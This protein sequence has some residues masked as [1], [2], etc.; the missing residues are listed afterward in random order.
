MIKNYNILYSLPFT[1]NNGLI[2]A[3]NS[4][5][6]AHAR[7]F[8]STNEKSLQYRKPLETHIDKFSNIEYGRNF[9]LW[10]C[11]KCKN[12]WSSAYTWISLNFCFNNKEILKIKDKQDKQKMEEWFSCDKL[13]DKYFLVEECRDCCDKHNN[14]VKILRYRNLKWS[15]ERDNHIPHRED[16]CVKCIKGYKCTERFYSTL[17]RTL[18]PVINNYVISKRFF[19]TSTQE[20]S[21][22]N[23]KSF[24]DVFNSLPNNYVKLKNISNIRGWVKLYCKDINLIDLRPNVLFM[25]KFYEFNTPYEYLYHELYYFKNN[26]L[27]LQKNYSLYLLY[28]PD[29]LILYS[30]IDLIKDYYEYT[31]N[32]TIIPKNNK[33]KYKYE[34][35]SLYLKIGK[36]LV[37]NCLK[38][39]YSNYLEINNIKIFKCGF[40]TFLK[41]NQDFFTFVQYKKYIIE[42]EL[43]EMNTSDFIEY[44][45]DIYLFI[46]YNIYYINQGFLE[47]DNTYNISNNSLRLNKQNE[48]SLLKV[49]KPK[50]GTYSNFFPSENGILKARKSYLGWKRNFFGKKNKR[51]YN[52]KSYDAILD[53]NYKFIDN[54]ILSKEDLDLNIKEYNN[55]NNLNINKENLN[56]CYINSPQN[57]YSIF[58]S[59]VFKNDVFKLIYNNI[60]NIIENNPINN[61]TQYKIENYLINQYK[62]LIFNK[63]KLYISDIDF[64]LFNKEFKNYCFSKIDEF[65]SYLNLLRD[66]LNS[67][68][69]YNKNINDFTQSIDIHNFYIKN[70]FNKLNNKEIISYMF[71]VLFLVV[72]YNDMVSTEDN[73]KDDEKTKIGVT[74]I[75]MDLGKI[76]SNFYITKLYKEYKKDNNI[77]TLEFRIFKERFLNVDKQYVFEDS[78][79]FLRLSGKLIEIMTTCGV[80]DIKIH[81]LN[82]RNLVVLKLSSDL[83]KVLD[84]KNPISILP[85]NLPMIVPPKDYNDNDL[86]GFLLN[87]VEYTQYLIRPKLGY[88]TSS[89]IEENN[90]IYD[91]VNSMMKTPFKVNKD[92][93]NYLL[94]NNHIHNLL[95][96]SDYKHEYSDIKRNKIQEKKYQ[97]FLSQ[98]MLEKYILLIADIYS[99]IPEIYFPLKLDN[100]GRL[101]PS[102]AFFHYQSSELA[103]ALIQFAIPDI[104]K[105][106]DHNAIEYLKTYGATCFGNGLNRKSYTK[107]LEWIKENW[108]NI[109]NFENGYL[110]S[111]A[112]DKFLFLAFCFEIRRFNTFMDNEHIDEFKTYLPI[113]LDGTCNGFQHLALLSNET[114][115]F[116]NLNLGESKKN[117]DPSDFYTHILD[118]LNIH[119]VRSARK[120]RG[121]DS[122]EIKERIERLLKLGLNRSLLKPIIM[123]DPYNATNRTLASYV[124][125]LLIY[126]HSDEKKPLLDKEGKQIYDKNNNPK[127]ESI[128]WYKIDNSSKYF[129]NFEDLEFLVKTID[130]IIYVKYP[131]IKILK[132]YFRDIGKIF[133]D[134]NI[135]IIWRLPTGLKVSQQYMEKHTIQINPFSYHSNRISLTITDKLKIDKHKQLSA[136]MPNLV[137]SLDAA[138]LT[139]L[140]ASLTKTINLNN[141][142]INFYSVHDCYGVTAKYVD[143]LIKMLR[144]VYIE[145]YSGEGYIEKFDEDVINTIIITYGENLCKYS[146]ENRTIYIDKRKNIVLPNLSVFLNVP[147]KTRVYKNL[148]KSIFLIK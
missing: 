56:T 48:L 130:E 107:R 82:D 145:L 42:K 97:K 4:M 101:Y 72:T 105:R 40:K 118:I 46:T 93:L 115:L 127:F 89:V 66:N 20:L 117:K 125:D 28:T 128:S 73:V 30:V 100:R 84:N 136:F 96:N 119:L 49:I 113:Q 38:Y 21:T 140:Y 88:K 16:L 5:Q 63:D 50:I 104:I 34:I 133:N 132:D 111:K 55:I 17:S 47:M 9:G 2:T 24:L 33:P 79:F 1:I 10:K 148:S 80:L 85:M 41:T 32:D 64:S 3:L 70:I 108:D 74:T 83:D 75:S 103:K 45:R 25:E 52:T 86:G 129:V 92:L 35:I 98:K 12:S 77:E 143:I 134:L 19:N 53:N 62:D 51:Y 147:N 57:K 124:R 90:I 95:I 81:K 71:Y 54:K 14:S 15:G 76:L 146:P 22:L 61:D 26:S 138:T 122:N 23:N 102:V 7:F 13:K 60:I 135:P 109:I 8:S 87:N 121:K 99:N 120:K 39:K 112:D 116:N 37:L 144:T 27:I 44:G 69:T 65:N 126:D 110:I 6:G 114:K 123:N 11:L 141:N 131:K 31:R 43:C 36:E 139:L 59:D 94:K 68:K 78:E 18:L 106:N 142:Y 29:N 67:N 137:H 91:T 58:N